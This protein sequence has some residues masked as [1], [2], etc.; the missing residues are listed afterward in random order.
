MAQCFILAIQPFDFTLQLINP[1]NEIH[2][3]LPLDDSL[4][5]FNT[6]LQRFRLICP[7]HVGQCD[8]QY[9]GTDKTFLTVKLHFYRPMYLISTRRFC[10]H[11]Y[12]LL[13]SSAGRSSPKLVTWN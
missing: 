4:Q 6:L 1:A 11:A 7:T 10:D 8:S 5:A 12:S 3:P 13:P 9:Y 2:Q